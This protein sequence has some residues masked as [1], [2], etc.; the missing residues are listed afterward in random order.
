VHEIEAQISRYLLTI[1]TINIGLG[2]AVGMTVHFLG[3]RNPI[4]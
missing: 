3:L 1:T 4:M 2:I